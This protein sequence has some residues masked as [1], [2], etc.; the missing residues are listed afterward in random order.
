MVHG[1]GSHQRRLNELLRQITVRSFLSTIKPSEKNQTYA[2]IRLLA[3]F[4]HARVFQYSEISF[5]LLVLHQE[6]FPVAR[7]KGSVVPPGI[8]LLLGTFETSP[9]EQGGCEHPTRISSTFPT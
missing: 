7:D 9:H 5:E 3:D 1:D 8:F 2:F 4:C 6:D